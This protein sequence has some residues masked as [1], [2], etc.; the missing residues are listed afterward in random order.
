MLRKFNYI[1]LYTLIYVN[2]VKQNT[3]SNKSRKL[4]FVYIYLKNKLCLLGI[5]INLKN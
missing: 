2:Y 3:I 4:D 5:L 1:F